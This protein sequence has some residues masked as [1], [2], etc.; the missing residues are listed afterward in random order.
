MPVILA[1]GRQRQVGLCKFQASLVYRASFRTARATQGRLYTL[2]KKKKKS[3]KK[4][5]F[6]KN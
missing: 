4:R 6:K 2:T 1:L 5:F 3:R